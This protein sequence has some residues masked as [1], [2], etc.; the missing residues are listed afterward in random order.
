MN[1]NVHNMKQWDSKTLE[2]VL[3]NGDWLYI[4]NGPP[5]SYFPLIFDLPR[6]VWITGR[7]LIEV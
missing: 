5:K 7:Q 1:E 6:I 2:K 4:N 3:Q